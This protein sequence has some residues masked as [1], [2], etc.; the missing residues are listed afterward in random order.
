MA[1][2][3]E[4]IILLLLYLQL[5]E[6]KTNINILLLSTLCLAVCT[7]TKGP[8]GALI[9]GGI[10][11]ACLYWF[12]YKKE[13]AKSIIWGI[14]ASLAFGVIYFL[15]LNSGNSIYIE[16]RGY[17]D[18]YKL[19]FSKT[20]IDNMTIVF[21]K[22][23]KYIRYY[24]LVNPWIFIPAAA[25][26]IIS[27]IKKR[28]AMIDIVLMGMLFAGTF[29]G[30]SIHYVGNSEMYFTLS[31]FPCAAILAGK[32]L[33]GYV[34][35]IKLLANKRYMKI[36]FAGIIIMFV[37]IGNYV[38]NWKQ[39][40]Q[41]CL[42]S[43]I[44]HLSGKYIEVDENKNN[45]MTTKE[46]EAYLWIMKNT[47]KD[48]LFL[49]DKTLEEEEYSYVP[50]V[51]SERYIYYYADENDMAEGKL[52]FSGNVV[53]LEKYKEKGIDYVIQNK[54]ISPDFVCPKDFGDIAYE[55]EEVIVYELEQ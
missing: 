49:S 10:G 55:N 38:F 21:F 15:L 54:K 46:Y 19:S 51:F 5:Q 3:F 17:V 47:D 6:K 11:I 13:F 7:G 37:M 16:N 1:L 25:Y 48:A 41:T 50:G 12:F 40:L 26:F 20:L 29:L 4:L 27:F 2:C 45:T 22:T 24:L 53:R 23:I 35:S 31:V 18:P 14:C 32:L 39:T 33:A 34:D 44:N 28:I 9:F 30:Y 42:E 43:G 52:C 8:T 36:V